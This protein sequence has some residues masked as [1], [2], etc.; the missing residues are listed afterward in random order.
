MTLPRIPILKVATTLT[1]GA[2]TCLCSYSQTPPKPP[3]FNRN[4]ILIDPAHGGSDT[5]A[6][7]ADNL[8]EKDVTLALAA[9]IRTLLSQA[10]FTIVTT[11]D[12]ELPDTAPL[13]PSDQRAN[14]ANHARA[15]ACILIHATASGSGVHISTS[16]LPEE[17]P[18]DAAT[19]IPWDTAQASYLAQSRRLANEL[20]VALV[21]AQIPT[22]LGRSS[23]RPLDNLTCP[24]V[25]LEIAPFHVSGADITPVNDPAYQQQ[26]AQAIATALTSWRSHIEPSA[27]PA[28]PSETP[29]PKPAPR[30][31]T[32]PAPKPSKSATPTT[33]KPAPATPTKSAPPKDTTPPDTAPKA[34]AQTSEPAPTTTPA[35]ASGEAR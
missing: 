12:A 23:V 5:G 32:S 10:G 9:T 6:H 26:V 30:L 20:G 7:L 2:I 1:L 3:A 15:L 31:Q 25:T 16:A 17:S 29:T 27:A 24:A 34:P 8:D 11:R 33:P 21:H 19:V 13:L 35:P 18:D 14:T 4:V 22:L 28:H